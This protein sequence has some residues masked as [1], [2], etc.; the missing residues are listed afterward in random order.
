MMTTFSWWSNYVKRWPVK[1]ALTLLL[2]FVL[3]LALGS[4]TVAHAMEP[5]VSLDNRVAYE[6]GHTPG[7]ADQVPADSDK[8]YPHHHSGCHEHQVGEPARICATPTVFVSKLVVRPPTSVGF[9]PKS[10][11]PEHRPPIA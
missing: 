8:G 6:M 11:S 4:G 1:S 9:A 3:S 10:P 5:V 7:D 2:A